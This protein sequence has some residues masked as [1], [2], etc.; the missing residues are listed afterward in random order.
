VLSL[1]QNRLS[2][3]TTSMY[4]YLGSLQAAAP[5]A[6]AAMSEDAQ[7]QQAALFEK[8]PEYA[9]EIGRLADGVV[10]VLWWPLGVWSLPGVGCPRRTPPP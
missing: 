6:G 2:D 8:A 1:A 3:L 4:S 10:A 7:R 5:P 9:K